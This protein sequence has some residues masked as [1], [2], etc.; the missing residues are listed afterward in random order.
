MEDIWTAS[1]VYATVGAFRFA[2]A[3][4]D[5]GAR[6]SDG[7]VTREFFTVQALDLHANDHD[8][9]HSPLD[10]HAND[11]DGCHSGLDAQAIDNDG[12]HSPLDSH[13]KDVRGCDSRLGFWA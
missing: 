9:S 13:A 1:E 8:G 10:L 7:C 11:D 6:L 4:E 3:A 12:C 2:A 5:G